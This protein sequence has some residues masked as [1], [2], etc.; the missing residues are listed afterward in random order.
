VSDI[1]STLR[2]NP[3]LTYGQICGRLRFACRLL[4]EKCVLTTRLIGGVV[5]HNDHLAGL[6][7]SRARSRLDDQVGSRLSGQKTRVA[8]VGRVFDRAQGAE[9]RFPPWQAKDLP[10]RANA[11]RRRVSMTTQSQAP[12]AAAQKTKTRAKLSSSHSTLSLRAVVCLTLFTLEPFVVRRL[13]LGLLAPT[14]SNRFVSVAAPAIGDTRLAL[15]RQHGP[16]DVGKLERRPKLL[17]WGG[18]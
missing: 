8:T 16:G 2:P 4:V 10:V 12:R 5:D 11:C 18:V 13:P 17:R 7:A 15:R 9:F 1:T 6:S 14:R 3:N